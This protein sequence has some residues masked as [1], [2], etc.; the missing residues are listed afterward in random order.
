MKMNGR[1]VEVFFYGPTGQPSGLPCSQTNSWAEIKERTSRAA[2][3]RA[4]P[5]AVPAEPGALGPVFGCLY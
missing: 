4:R 3:T 2:G 5:A 1:G